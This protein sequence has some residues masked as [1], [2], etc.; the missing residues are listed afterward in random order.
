MGNA[1]CGCTAPKAANATSDAPLVAFDTV[2]DDTQNFRVQED[3]ALRFER[4]VER[5]G[6]DHKEVVWGVRINALSALRVINDAVVLVAIFLLLVELLVEALAQVRRHVPQ[7]VVGCVRV[8][9]HH[10]LEVRV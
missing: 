5:L 8:E 3:C 4:S 2:Q 7:A 1:A 9:Q 10:A 6:H